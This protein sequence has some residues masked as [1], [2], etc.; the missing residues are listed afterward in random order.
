MK[1]SQVHLR[2]FRNYHDEVIKFDDHL[3]III[4]DNAQGKTNI[5]EAIVLCSNCRSFKDVDDEAMIMH[6]EAFGD[7]EICFIDDKPLKVKVI[8]SPKGKTLVANNNIVNKTSDFIGLLNVIIFEPS[9]IAFFDKAPSYRRKII[10]MEISKVDKKYVYALNNYYKLLKERNAYLKT[11]DID[12]NYLAVLEA[13]M[14]DYQQII[15]S[16]RKELVDIINKRLSKL[17]SKLNDQTLD[18]KLNYQCCI[19][20]GDIKE[21]LINMYKQNHKKDLLFNVTNAGIHREDLVFRLNGHD[22]SDV[23]S[24]GQKRLAIIAFKL[25]LINYIKYKTNKLPILLLDDILS[26]LDEAKQAL[27]LNTISSDIQTIITTTMINSNLYEK[28]FKVIKIKNG[29]V[30]GNK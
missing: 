17:Y 27:L 23:A 25:M 24:Q 18:L 10:D 28:S 16:K 21:N 22:I 30:G 7:C 2:N 19:D 29:K 6:G 11:N 14:I 15:I 3:N 9:H 8:I 1:I 26:E 4:G 20:E 5:L 12:L 13:K